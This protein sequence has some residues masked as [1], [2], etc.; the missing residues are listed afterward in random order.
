MENTSIKKTDKIIYW[1]ATGFLLLLYF[2]SGTMYIF[3]TEM[4][5][6]NMLH[7]GF[8][9]W[10]TYLLI[11]LKFSGISVVAFTKWTLLREWA[12]A[13]M[14]FNCLLALVAH[15][16]AGDPVSATIPAAIGTVFVL[17]S[18]FY[19]KRLIK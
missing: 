15:V 18:Y 3:K 1:V 14:F 7:L 19:S 17:T 13:G 6:E 2:G 12:Y 16:M 11:P 10:L 4:V 5:N 9:V 8:P